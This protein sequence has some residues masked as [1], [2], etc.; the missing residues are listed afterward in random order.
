MLTL[1]LIESTIY[2]TTLQQDLLHLHDSISAL[3]VQS[4][5]QRE[6]SWYNIYIQRLHFSNFFFFF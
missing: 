2:N 6:G 3:I 5:K 1:L 4:Y